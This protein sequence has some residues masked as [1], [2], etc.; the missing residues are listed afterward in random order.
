MVSNREKVWLV[1]EGV[2]L[3]DPLLT[4]FRRLSIKF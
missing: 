3:V 1:I 4:N 2:G